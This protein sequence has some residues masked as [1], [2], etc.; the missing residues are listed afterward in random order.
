MFVYNKYMFIKFGMAMGML[1]VYQH[2]EQLHEWC[3][4]AHSDFELCI[5]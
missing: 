3:V 4:E 1:A 2:I 5:W